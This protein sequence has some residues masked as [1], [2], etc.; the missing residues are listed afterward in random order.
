M[1]PMPSWEVA[2]SVPPI[3]VIRSRD[4]VRPSPIPPDVVDVGVDTVERQE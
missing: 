2:A 3:A 1:L 4:N